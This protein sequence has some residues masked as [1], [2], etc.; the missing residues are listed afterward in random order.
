MPKLFKKNGD[1]N[2]DLH[3]DS[4]PSPKILV[5]KDLDEYKFNPQKLDE[6]VNMKHTNK[7]Y[8]DNKI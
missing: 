5:K 7:Q 2:S 6:L 1:L 8:R 4:K 3:Y